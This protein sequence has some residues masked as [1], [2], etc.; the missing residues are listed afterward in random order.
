MALRMYLAPKHERPRDAGATT[1]P[2]VDDPESRTSGRS[3]Q[4]VEHQDESH[5]SDTDQPPGESESSDLP[6]EETSDKQP[7]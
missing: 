6:S 1:W 5:K 4:D 7:L 3:G 2:D